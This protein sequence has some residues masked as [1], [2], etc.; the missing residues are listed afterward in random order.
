MQNNEAIF[1]YFE[2][3]HSDFCHSRRADFCLQKFQQFQVP[4]YVVP[5]PGKVLKGGGGG[6]LGVKAKGLF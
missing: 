3:F 6:V 4:N 2:N 1:L 5:K